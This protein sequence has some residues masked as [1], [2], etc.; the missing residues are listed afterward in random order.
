MCVILSSLKGECPLTTHVLKE[1]F[2]LAIYA[3]KI[4]KTTYDVAVLKQNT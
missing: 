3:K 1:L 4:K 2:V